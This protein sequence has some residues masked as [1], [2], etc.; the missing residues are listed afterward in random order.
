MIFVCFGENAFRADFVTICEVGEKKAYTPVTT[1]FSRKPQTLREKL[2]IGSLA[3]FLAR[4][5]GVTRV[6]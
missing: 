3:P 2:G 4:W 6:W 5:A 1:A